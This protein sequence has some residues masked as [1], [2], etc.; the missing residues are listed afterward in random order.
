MSTLLLP[1]LTERQKSL[2]LGPMERGPQVPTRSS[3]WW[4]EKARDA[5]SLLIWTLESSAL[6]TRQNCDNIVT[7]FKGGNNPRGPELLYQLYSEL[8]VWPS[9]CQSVS[10]SAKKSFVELCHVSVIVLSPGNTARNRPPQ[11]GRSVAMVSIRELDHLDLLSDRWGD[12]A[13]PALKSLPVL[14]IGDL[15][16]S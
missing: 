10:R 1:P 2:P 7:G 13:R 15:S 5:S 9:F 14:K 11:G 8:G 6:K 4:V 12:W 3:L 16:A